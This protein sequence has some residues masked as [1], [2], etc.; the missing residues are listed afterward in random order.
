MHGTWVIEVG[1]RKGKHAHNAPLFHPDISL[2]STK[3]ETH[4]ARSATSHVHVL[5]LAARR[6][7][8]VRELADQLVDRREVVVAREQR[9]RRRRNLFLF[10]PIL[11]HGLF[12][13]PRLAF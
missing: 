2:A 8:A 10:W 6:E 11:N 12:A 7:L 3:A 5:A 4:N 1:S 13:S 9:R